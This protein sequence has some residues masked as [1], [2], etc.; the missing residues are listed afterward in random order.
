M[1][2]IA[3]AIVRVYAKPEAEVRVITNKRNSE[4]EGSQLSR[5]VEAGVS[6]R[7]CSSLFA[8]VHRV[9]TLC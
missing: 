4:I 9:I 3:D 1:E 8:A 5:L 2:Q 6:I 7:S